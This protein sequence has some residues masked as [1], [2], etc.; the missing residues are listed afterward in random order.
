MAHPMEL[1]RGREHAPTGWVSVRVR[2]YLSALL[3]MGCFYFLPISRVSAWHK[4]SPGAEAWT[5]AFPLGARGVTLGPIECPDGPACGYGSSYSEATLDELARMGTNWIALT[6]FGRVWST[7]STEITPHLEE[8]LERAKHELRTMVAQA[9]ERGIRVLV[10]PHIYVES[11]GSRGDEAGKWRGETSRASAADWQAYLRSYRS[12]VL[13]W[14]K[15]ASQAQVEAFSLGAECKAF[16]GRFGTFWTEL[17]DAVRGLY[18]GLL[19]YNANWWEEVE[20]VIFWDQ[21]DV[22]GVNAFFDMAKEPGAPYSTYVASAASYRDRM[23]ALSK[24]LDMPVMFT[25][26]GYGARKDAGLEPWKWPENHRGVSFSEASQADAFRA[27]AEVFLREPWFAGFFVWRYPSNLDDL[28]E[29]VWGFSPHAL[30]AED[31]LRRIFRCEW[32]VDRRALWSRTTTLPRSGLARITR[33]GAPAITL[34]S[35]PLP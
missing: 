3:T 27:F 2:V 21:V 35:C 9:H 17:I 26:V 10:I 31:A 22:I 30:A 28:Q 24:A 20:T 13:E 18:S 12:F 34:Q 1:R 23:A 16:S 11:S 5:S 7:E 32:E 19:T 8:S 6:P 14:A 15:V 29:P 25:E 4:L 33:L